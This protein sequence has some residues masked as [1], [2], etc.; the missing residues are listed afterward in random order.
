MYTIQVYSKVFGRQK[1]MYED[2]HLM[3]IYNEGELK[4]LIIGNSLH[5]VQYICRMGYHSNR[6][7]HA[8]QSNCPSASEWRS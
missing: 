6:K 3:V 8:Y 5:M 2:V 1:V 4:I 7:S